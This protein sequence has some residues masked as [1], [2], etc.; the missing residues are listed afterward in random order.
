MRVSTS[1]RALFPDPAVSASVYCSGRLDE[2]VAG[3]LVPL[4]S[5][6]EKGERA[7]D[8]YLWFMR[9]ARGGE[10]LKIRLH[11]PEELRL[12]MH[13]SLESTATSF[14]ARLDRTQPERRHRAQPLA[15]PIDSEDRSGGERLDGS[16]IWTH[17]ERSAIALG[18]AQLLS[19]D[20]YVA[21]ATACLGM[22][23]AILLRNLEAL[24]THLQSGT[25]QR[26]H[27]E[28]VLTALASRQLTAEQC[29]EYL[30][31]HR[32]T[33]LRAVLKNNPRGSAKMQELGEKFAARAAIMAPAIPGLQS[34]L[35]QLCNKDGKSDLPIT[36]LPWSRTVDDFLDH[37]NPLRS[38][39]GL[40]FDLYAEDPL[41]PPLFKMLHV[42][43]NQL[44]L[45][46]LNE[47]FCYNLLLTALGEI[48]ILSK[49]PELLPAFVRLEASL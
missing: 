45:D 1:T 13:D 41:F 44:G 20:K 8:C 6:L 12:R 19:D 33:L 16:L 40:C 32:D 25:R 4:W 9:Y 21:L 48:D 35:K 14:L 3:I 7:A 47:A 42:H 15:P 31:Y 38:R 10:H 2:A 18:P 46:P 36:L 43:A 30:L 27:L 11:G 28:S 34:A 17:Y 39:P 49:P 26:V 24:G 37:L 23:A 5:E 22:G 29:K